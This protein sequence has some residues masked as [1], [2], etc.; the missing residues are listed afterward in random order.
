MS[1]LSK[2]YF[3]NEEAAFAHLKGVLWPDAPVC[4]HCGSISAKH[5]DL[6][7]TRVGLRKCCKGLPEAIHGAGRD[8]FQ[9]GPYPA[10]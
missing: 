4:P 6:R 9:S 2:P 1:V 5:Y 7:K 3:H 8:C 10:A